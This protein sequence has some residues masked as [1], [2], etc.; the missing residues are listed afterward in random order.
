LLGLTSVQ[1]FFLDLLLVSL[2]MYPLRNL[3]AL[4]PRPT[5]GVPHAV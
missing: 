5:T 3:Q 4:R 1:D 2:T